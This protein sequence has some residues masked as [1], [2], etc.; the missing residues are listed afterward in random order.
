[1]P[2]FYLKLKKNFDICHLNDLENFT[3]NPEMD[4]SPEKISLEKGLIKLYGVY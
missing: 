1:M 3:L 4:I 2:L